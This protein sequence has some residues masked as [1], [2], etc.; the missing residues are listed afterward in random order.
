MVYRVRMGP[1]SQKVAAEM[2][3]EQLQVGGVETALVRVQR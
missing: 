2:T 1:F 3:R